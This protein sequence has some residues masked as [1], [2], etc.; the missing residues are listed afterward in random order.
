MPDAGADPA[1][2]HR[3]ASLRGR[4]GKRDAGA[5][6]RSEF[7]SVEGAEGARA[8]RSAPDPVLPARAPGGQFVGWAKRSVPTI[9]TTYTH[10]DGGHSASA[11]LPTL[12]SWLTRLRPF[13][14]REHHAVIGPAV[15]VRKH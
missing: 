6:C 14:R 12:R 2:R 13:R 4:D 10:E 7:V 15:A 3:G 9:L 1:R 5:E 11:P 8:A